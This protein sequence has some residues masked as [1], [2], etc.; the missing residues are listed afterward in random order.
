MFQC[1]SELVM[2]LKHPKCIKFET[3]FCLQ[4]DINNQRDN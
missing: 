1:T 4:L 3:F 2:L